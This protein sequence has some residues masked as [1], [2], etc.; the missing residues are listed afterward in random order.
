MR[1]SCRPDRAPAETVIDVANTRAIVL[2][3][4]ADV[5]QSFT[6]ELRRYLRSQSEVP[7]T[8]QTSLTMARVLP[9]SD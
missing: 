3:R 6:G 9:P 2:S 7:L 4:P 5:R 1:G 8:Q